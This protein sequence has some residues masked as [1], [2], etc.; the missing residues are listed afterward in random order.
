MQH[1]ILFF[2]ACLHFK[3]TSSKDLWTKVAAVRRKCVVFSKMF[4]LRSMGNELAPSPQENYFLCVYMYV[5]IKSVG[6]QSY[7]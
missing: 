2:F 1:N 5:G 3:W 6:I 7:L 4:V